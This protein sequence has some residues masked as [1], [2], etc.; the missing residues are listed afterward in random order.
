[1]SKPIY[2]LLYYKFVD[3]ADARFEVMQHKLVC[4]G[5]GLK[6]RILIGEEGIKSTAATTSIPI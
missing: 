2:V 6:G 5:I 1:M 4:E 3:V